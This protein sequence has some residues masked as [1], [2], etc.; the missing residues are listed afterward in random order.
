MA[1]PGYDKKKDLAAPET[2]RQANVPAAAYTR[3]PPHRPC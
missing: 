3:C 2:E 1:E